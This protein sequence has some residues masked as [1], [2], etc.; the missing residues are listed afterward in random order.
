MYNFITQNASLVG[1]LPLSCCDCGFEPRRGH[2]C[3]FVSCVGSGLF[4]G[5]IPLP[6]ESDQCGASVCDLETSLMRRPRLQQGCCST[7]REMY[8]SRWRIS[9]FLMLPI[10]LL[11]LSHN[12]VMS[13]TLMHRAE[14][15]K[16]G[17]PHSGVQAA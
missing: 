17:P 16:Y 14:E 3:S 1:L 2:D 11:A 6:E 15:S 10:Y 5:P 12:R 8:R 9:L 13:N 4:D 7:G